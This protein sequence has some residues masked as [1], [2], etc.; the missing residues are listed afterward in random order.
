MRT[1]E[2]LKADPRTIKAEARLRSIGITDAWWEGLLER[3]SDLPRYHAMITRETAA[4]AIKRRS[5]LAKKMRNLGAELDNDSDVSNLI[6]M[7]GNDSYF[8]WARRDQNLISL[9]GWLAECATSLEEMPSKKN[10]FP[11]VD[12]RRGNSLKAYVIRGVFQW[13]DLYLASGR[14][15]ELEIVTASHPSNVDTSLLAS[16]VLNES[17]SPNDVTQIRKHQR[18]K[19]YLD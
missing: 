8:L 12:T 15:R 17:I 16:A 19:Y 5:L 9:G 3:I 4:E 14:G 7:I 6:P 18:K 13:I 10:I 1:L 2:E 11:A